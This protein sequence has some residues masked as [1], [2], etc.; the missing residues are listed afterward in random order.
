MF[1]GRTEPKSQ[2]QTTAADSVPANSA[3]YSSESETRS[4]ENETAPKA[5]T[6]SATM[7]REISEGLL[8]AFLGTG[9]VITGEASFKTTLRVDGEFSGRIFSEEGTLIVAPGSRVEANIAVGVAKIQGMVIG[10]IVAQDRIELG[11]DAH[12]K[13]NIKAPKLIIE[14]GA[15][16]DGSC[17]MTNLDPTE[18]ELLPPPDEDAGPPADPEVFAPPEAQAEATVAQAETTV[19]LSERDDAGTASKIKRKKNVLGTKSQQ[20]RPKVATGKTLDSEQIDGEKIA[21]A[22]GGMGPGQ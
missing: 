20:P 4:A 9:A 19:A 18:P 5:A 12:V 2:S 16:L 3:P 22:A 21:A 10:D 11:R 13:G 8:S 15:A 14:D 1:R 6:E 7:A 17:R